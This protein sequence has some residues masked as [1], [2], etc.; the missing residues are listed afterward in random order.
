MQAAGKVASASVVGIMVERLKPRTC[1]FVVAVLPLIVACS[2]FVMQEKAGPVC[3]FGRGE[4]APLT[5]YCC[6]PT[7]AMLTLD[8]T[9]P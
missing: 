1:F 3:C 5:A 8:I 9:Q 6:M 7:C 2:A 4:T